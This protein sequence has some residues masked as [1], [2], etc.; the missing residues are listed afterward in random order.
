MTQNALEL[1]NIT[2][3]FGPLRALDNVN[4]TIK[5]NEVIG[6]IGENG[7]GK[8]TLL[9]VLAGIHEPDSGDIVIHGTKKRL[10]SPSGAA[11]LGIG[12]VHQEQSLL[13]NLSVAENIH[14]GA[15]RLKGE[16]R[17][18][19]AGFYNW[20][21]MNRQGRDTLT[22]VG[23][24]V[25]ANAVVEDLSFADR[26]MVEIAKAVR[27][28]EQGGNDPLLILDE[29]TSVLEADETAILEREVQRLKEL[30][31][32]IF[33]SHR[34]QE[35]LRVSDRIYVLRHGKVV[36]ERRSADV[37]EDEL[38]ELMTGRT[39]AHTERRV[40]DSAA[41]GDL[42]AVDGL[43]KD[44]A[45]SDVSF[46]IKPGEVCAFVGTNGSG[47]EEVARSL[48]GAEPF[49]AG[50]FT[51]DGKQFR[52]ISIRR[53]IASGIAYLPAERKVEGMIPGMTLGEN[54][55]LAHPVDGQRGPFRLP[56][57]RVAVT[58]DWIQQ[59]DVRPPN[60]KADIAQLSGGNQQKVVLGK[61]FLAPNLKLAILDHPLRGLDPGAKEF[62]AEL[63]RHAAS[64]G[65][66]VMLLADTLEE[67]L[68][69]ATTIIVMKDGRI[70]ERHDLSERV[71]TMA[72]LVEG[73]V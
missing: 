56:R 24:N 52:R 31:S 1:V 9:K 65:V 45:F 3:N 17:S 12:V 42:L 39:V 49:D 33:V 72:E 57:K 51:L 13:S 46:T 67:A 19:V 62:V 47:R 63:I 54:L 23:S 7:A 59:M 40:Q 20:S 27:I 43:S 21:E 18:V 35:V 64:N 28:A 16:K 53:A 25:P 36:A 30:G 60:P 10:R 37:V 29:P 4:I 73:M 38:F 48:F 15:G 26:Q 44:G 6:L 55:T 50:S 5:R 14:L 68:G 61:W 71:P 34:L 8:S 70:T 58:N 22:T 69:N 66:G 32:V 41:G 11:A 2:K